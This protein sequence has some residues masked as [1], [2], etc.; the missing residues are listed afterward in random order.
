MSWISDNYEKAALGGSL[1]VAIA[2]GAALLNNMGSVEESFNRDSVKRNDDVSIPGLGKINIIKESLTTVQPIEQPEENGRKVD[3]MTGVP[4]FAKRGDIE[5]PVDLGLDTV[6]VHAPIPNSWWLENE[7]DPGYSDSPD[8]DP[9]ED[10]FSNREEFVAKTDPNEFKSHPDPVT[11]LQLQ[12]VKTTQ[13]FLK[14]SDFGAGKV[15]FKLLNTRGVQRNKMDDPVTK[16]E[17]ILFKDALMKDRFKFNE[18]E[19]MEVKKSGITQKIKIWVIE[20]LKPNKVGT[21]YR[22][23]KSG[24]RVEGG[25]SGIIDST[26]E[27]ALQALRE[28]G[29]PFKIEENTRFALPFK[30]DA[31]E[32]PYLLKK[33]DVQ[34]KTV[35]IEYLDG[36][37]NKTPLV[38]HF[39]K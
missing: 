24:K 3:L 13:Y 12:S 23:N 34:A 25:P 17:V 28:G 5:N 32:K 39:P 37:G 38:L 20:D 27:L 11:K 22:F 35:E 30:E 36:K 15:K 1:V 2:L 21:E 16:G 18:L 31:T 29:N 19:E 4:L 9:D 8:R 10:G 7:I 33:I 6:V 26:A 14:P